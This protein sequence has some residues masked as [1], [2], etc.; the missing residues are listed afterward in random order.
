MNDFLPPDW[1]SIKRLE[2]RKKIS[3]GRREEVKKRSMRIM[4]AVEV[5]KYNFVGES[6]T[7]F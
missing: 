5:E 3:K 2:L 1:G 4:W 6:K 7:A